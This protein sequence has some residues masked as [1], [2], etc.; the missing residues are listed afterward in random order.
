MALARK[1]RYDP[2]LKHRNNGRET[3]WKAVGKME[4][5][6]QIRRQ[7]IPIIDRQQWPR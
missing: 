5:P 1:N 6:S 2:Y 4:N 7:P 3:N